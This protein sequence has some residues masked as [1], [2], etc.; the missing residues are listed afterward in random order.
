MGERAVS[1]TP[2][3]AR[4]AD[5]RVS[6]TGRIH[7][8]NAKIYVGNNRVGQTLHVLFDQHTIEIFDPDGT[9]LGSVPHPG[10][11]PAGT[12]KVLTIRPWHPHRQ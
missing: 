12:F 7:I 1:D 4:W 11:V 5:R 8:C 2:D 3:A 10:K 6:T 9:L